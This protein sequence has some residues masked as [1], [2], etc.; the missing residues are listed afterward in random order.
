[1][2]KNSNINM[3]PTYLAFY[4]VSAYGKKKE[5]EECQ[6]EKYINYKTHAAA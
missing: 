6:Q 2:K 5:R 1:M 3:T 4:L